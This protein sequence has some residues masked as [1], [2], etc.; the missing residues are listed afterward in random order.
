MR[1]RDARTCSGI[2]FNHVSPR[3]GLEFAPRKVASGVAR[4]KRGLQRERRLGNLDAQRDWGYAPDYVR[5]I[6]AMLQQERPDDFV[7][8]TGRTHTVRH[9]CELA[10]GHVGLGYR[11]HVVSA[12]R[13]LRPAEV[14]LL[15]G[16][17]AKARS[18]L[19]WAP[20]TSFEDLVALM[21]EAELALLDKG[22]PVATSPY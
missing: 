14:D 18:A 10:F 17:A 9:L 1:Y 11:D 15:V 4:I 22:E 13:Y 20:R 3:H 7:L 12:G 21:V 16:D 5:G 19:G 2:L 6:W 8:A